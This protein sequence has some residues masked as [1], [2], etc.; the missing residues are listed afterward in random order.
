[1]SAKAAPLPISKAFPMG[2]PV[3]NI[4]STSVISVAGFLFETRMRVPAFA[5][6]VVQKNTHVFG[7]VLGSDGKCI[8]HGHL[9][10][11]PIW[12]VRKRS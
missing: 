10:S 2:F 9:L 12:S 11:R 4:I 3:A 8:L 1:M 7:H 5:W 6:V